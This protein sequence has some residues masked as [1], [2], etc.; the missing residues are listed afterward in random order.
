MQHEATII[1]NT[2]HASTIAH[3]LCYELL[4]LLFANMRYP[5]LP[6]RTY[7]KDFE[8]SGELWRLWVSPMLKTLLL[9]GSFFG[10]LGSANGS[11]PVIIISLI[12]CSPFAIYHIYRMIISDFYCIDVDNFLLFQVLASSSVDFLTIVTTIA[13]IVTVIMISMPDQ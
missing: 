10:M 3:Y 4:A 5:R 8:H 1:L 2:I 6:T 9:V 13:N 7:F 11:L 12:T